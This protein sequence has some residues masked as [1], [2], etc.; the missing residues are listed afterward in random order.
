MK[1]IFKYD[2]ISH[3]TLGISTGMEKNISSISIARG[4]KTFIR[5]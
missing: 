3:V 5:N 2:K 4:V 1:N